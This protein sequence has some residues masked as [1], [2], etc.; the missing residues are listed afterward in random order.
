MTTA[1]TVVGHL[2][3]VFAHGPGRRRAQQHRHHARQRHDHRHGVHAVRRPV[4]L[5]A[6]GENTQ[7]V[8]GRRRSDGRSGR[9]HGRRFVETTAPPRHRA[10][11]RDFPGRLHARIHRPPAIFI[12]PALFMRSETRPPGR[13]Y[14][15]MFRVFG[16]RA[17]VLASPASLVPGHHTT[18]EV[19]VLSTRALTKIY[20]GP[21]TALNGIDLD[22]PVGMFGLLGPNGA[23]KSTFMKILAGTP[24]T[25]ARVP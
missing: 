9:C 17:A 5:H 8:G 21:V 4:D 1:A 16:G 23:G 15:P 7:P 18:Q 22:V 24:R 12:R 25:D 19:P 13:P 20:P 14:V 2:P 6:G 11:A 3:L 10:G